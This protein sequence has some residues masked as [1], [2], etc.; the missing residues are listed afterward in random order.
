MEHEK[1]TTMN[2]RHIFLIILESF[3]A[4][5]CSR[6]SHGD[7][8]LVPIQLTTS[9][10]ARSAIDR[11]EKTPL[12]LIVGKQENDLSQLWTGIADGGQIKLTPERYYPTD[13]STLYLRGLYPETEIENN[14]AHYSLTGNE[15][16]LF[17]DVLTGS[18]TRP[19]DSGN[20]TLTFRHL[21]AQLNVTIKAGTDFPTEYRLKSIRINGSSSETT[22]DLLQGTLSFS[23]EAAPIY[24]YYKES[25]TE[26]YPLAPNESVSLG[27]LLVQPGATLTA[28]IVLSRDDVE[29]HH[30]VINDIPIKFE[31]GS[32][33]TGLAY[34]VEIKIPTPLHLS[35]IL[36]EWTDGRNG[37]GGIT[38]PGKK[39]KENITNY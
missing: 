15:D 31:G 1:D 12:S 3:L 8:E 32:S 24:L 9:I 38:V 4:I 11:F 30:L 36:T 37:T 7:E 26:G 29:E 33:Q 20:G 19:F 35:A 21:L 5:G 17:A 22:L 13:G 16:L 34:H 23:T 2:K 39:T 10:Q 18:A 14:K 27:S 25:H 6:H 28:D